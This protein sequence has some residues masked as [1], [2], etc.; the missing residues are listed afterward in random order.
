M[1]KVLGGIDEGDESAGGEGI[2]S[3]MWERKSHKGLFPSIC[4][5]ALALAQA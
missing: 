4:G 1:R 5:L 2:V 3:T